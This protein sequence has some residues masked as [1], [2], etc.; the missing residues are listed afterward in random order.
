TAIIPIASLLIVG[1][2]FLGATTLQEFALALFIGLLSGAYS[3]FFIAS[4]TLAILKEREP[5]YRDIRRRMETR[6]VRT[7]RTTAADEPVAGEAE[8]AGPDVESGE[9]RPVTVGAPRVATNIPPRP[10]KKGKRR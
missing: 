9:R 8:V 7:T 6:G 1:S 2:Y 5:R 10:R 3:S 4:P